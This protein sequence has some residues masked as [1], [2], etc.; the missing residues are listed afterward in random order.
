MIIFFIGPFHCLFST[1]LQ[2]RRAILL[3]TLIRYLLGVFLQ[4]IPVLV[5]LAPLG[6]YKAMQLIFL[7][8]L[9]WKC[10]AFAGVQP[11]IY[12]EISTFWNVKL[13]SDILQRWKDT[14]GVIW[15]V[16]SSPLN[17]LFN[18]IIKSSYININFL[19]LSVKLCIYET[20]L[21]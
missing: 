10:K 5:V 17:C 11:F 15:M 2:R 1:S 6:C 16:N 3:K 18:L 7:F 9:L 12:Y 21:G 4:D 19:V 20:S 13:L 8:K 14:E